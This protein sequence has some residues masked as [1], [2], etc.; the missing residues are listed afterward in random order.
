MD[1]DFQ[2]LDELI[3]SVLENRIDAADLDRL[4]QRLLNDA[5][6][7]RHYLHRLDLHQALRWAVASAATCES[8]RAM[9]RG[10]F[11]ADGRPASTKVFSIRWRWAAAAAVVAAAVGLFALWPSGPLPT[12]PVG[13]GLGPGRHRLVDGRATLRFSDRTE[14][15]LEGPCDFELSELR[16][17]LHRGLALVRSNHRVS[18][19]R[20]AFRFEIKTPHLGLQDLGAETGLR[21]TERFTRLSV[22]RGEVRAT[23]SGRYSGMV[24]QMRLGR[25]DG[26]EVT[27]EGAVIS[28]IVADAGL[29]ETLRS[30]RPRTLVANPGFEYPKSEGS[31]S[32]AAA[33]W[34]LLSHPVA[35]ADPMDLGAGV[36]RAGLAGGADRRWPT[37][38]EGTQWAYLSAR[39][40]KNGRTAY[41]SMHQ[42]VGLVE[43][44]TT[45][46]L[47]MTVGWPLKQA[48]ASVTVGL[49]AGS[50]RPTNALVLWRE[51]AKPAPGGMVELD[52]THRMSAYSPY[53]GQNL[54]LVIEAVPSAAVGERRVL[55]DNIRLESADVRH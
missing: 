12:E 5:Q 37:P 45:Y 17:L 53:R 51:A 48:G 21:V 30:N 15:L 10:G 34:D 8:I 9:K 32:L 18:D 4:Q 14:L 50:R 24:Q 13:G 40:L 38:S 28:G 16:L 36:L 3:D 22:F 20:P 1:R 2:K 55:L 26:V 35:N 39:T 43:N 6:A 23:V 52:L 41:A 33:G 47:R 19:A 54:F 11:D 29:F 42:Q 27:R 25:D 44:N 49:Y 31:R 46:R 7:Q